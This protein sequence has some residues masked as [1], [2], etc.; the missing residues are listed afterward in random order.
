MIQFLHMWNNRDNILSNARALE[1][2]GAN[3]MLF[4]LFSII[5]N[6]EHKHTH[7]CFMMQQSAAA[8]W[9]LG[10]WPACRSWVP[11]RN[12]AQRSWASHLAV[13]C[14]FLCF[15]DFLCTIL[16]SSDTIEKIF[17]LAA[18][19]TSSILVLLYL[20]NVINSP[21]KNIKLFYHTLAKHQHFI[22]SPQS[23]KNV[24]RVPFLFKW[25]RYKIITNVHKKCEV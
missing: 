1:G 20:T 19:M 14:L 10:Q 22:L 11:L 4:I 12:M 15:M 23:N 18:S 13:L 24:S 8:A 25:E 16:F 5:I 9:A 17:C 7:Q 3:S 6:A 21:H 2:H